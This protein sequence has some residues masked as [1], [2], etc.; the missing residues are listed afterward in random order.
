ME[1]KHG[2][3][4][5]ILVH[6][7]LQVVN[8]DLKLI[9]P[10]FKQAMNSNFSLTALHRVLIQNTITG[11]TAM[12]NKALADL[13]Y[14][15]PKYCVMHDWWLQLVAA[16]FGEIGHLDDT[17][18]LYRQHGANIIGAKDVRR[19]SYKIDR[20]LHSDEVKKAI[21]ITYPQAESFLHIYKEHLTCQQ[22]EIIKSYCSIPTMRKL[23][24]WYTTCKLKAFKNGFSRNVAY[25]LYI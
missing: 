6:T 8:Q 24:K 16:A 18:V 19:F 25:F 11:C 5:P 21:S 12:Y 4:T 20:F 13:L 10:S 9:T 17:T 7:D 15:K 3:D 22:Q 23:A 2:S 1:K 14:R